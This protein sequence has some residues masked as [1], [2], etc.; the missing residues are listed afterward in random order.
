MG[1]SPY[2]NIRASGE[3]AHP[4]LSIWTLSQPISSGGLVHGVPD[5]FDYY[6]RYS[7]DVPVSV[8]ILS[9]T[10]FVQMGNCPGSDIQSKLQCVTGSITFYSPATTQNA[11]FTLAEGCGGYIA[12][13]YSSTSG[14]F[15]P[16]ISIR[17]NPS[18][19]LTG[20]CVSAS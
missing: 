3:L 6:I 1:A 8:A 9:S 10:Q 18:S 11:V 5:T 16:N 20:A 12:V 4:T 13:Y 15:H 19:G 7:S 17:Y 14:T 2:F